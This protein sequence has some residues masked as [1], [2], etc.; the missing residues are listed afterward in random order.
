[1][2]DS[3]LADLT[4][5]TTPATTDLAYLVVDPAGTPL[6]RKVTV[7]NLLKAN[8]S[9]LVVVDMDRV[10]RT[11]GNITA[12]STSWTNVDTGMDLTLTAASGDIVEVSISTT[13][14]SASVNIFLDCVTMV[15]GSPVNSLGLNAAAPTSTT[16]D[17]IGGW[18]G[19]T[20]ENSS[21]GSP[22]CYTLQGGDIS[23]GTVTLRLRYRTSAATN[24]TLTAS[25]DRPFHFNAR[26][27]RAV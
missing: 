20:G 8:G 22:V 17:G 16:Q 4:A 7:G 15:G 25:T 5:T 13:A 21:I 10:L 24:K 26:I 14:N 3:K 1:M 12:N 19:A 18:L 11:S 9:G 27:W 23:T 6:D 2:A